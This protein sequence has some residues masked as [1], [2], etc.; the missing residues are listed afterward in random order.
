MTLSRL[1]AR[2]SGPRTR[3]SAILA[4]LIVVSGA[5]TAGAQVLY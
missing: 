5:T 3:D 4:V 2:V 1:V